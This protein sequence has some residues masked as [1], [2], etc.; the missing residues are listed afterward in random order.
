MTPQPVVRCNGNGVRFRTRPGPKRHDSSPGYRRRQAST[1]Q[2]PRVASSV[3]A[4][5]SLWPREL[6]LAQMLLY[7]EAAFLHRS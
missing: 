2:V 5:S 6:A 7:W 1:P 3:P 4:W